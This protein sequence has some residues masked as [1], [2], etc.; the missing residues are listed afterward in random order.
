MHILSQL[1]HVGYCDC[2]DIDFV[3]VVLR[4]LMFADVIVIQLVG[5]N[6]C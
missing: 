6:A 3:N 1:G 2:I 5:V 4:S